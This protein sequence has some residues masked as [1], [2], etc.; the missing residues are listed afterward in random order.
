MM[1]YILKTLRPSKDG[2]M[3]TLVLR[4]A[5]AVGEEKRFLINEQTYQEGGA[6]LVGEVVDGQTV[7]FFQACVDRRESVK[8]ALRLLGYSDKSCHTLTQMLIRR[9][10]SPEVAQEATEEAVRMGYLNERR[11]VEIAIRDMVE[12]KHYGARRILPALCAK[13]Y[14]RPL[15][16][17]ILNQLVEEGE[18]DFKEAFRALLFKKRVEEIEDADERK[19]KIK[20][21]AYT[22]G[23]K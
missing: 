15:V 5:T 11:A 21:L 19:E 17:E 18:V 1:D 10:F 12:R 23:Y 22:Y 9:G 4:P 14:P 3:L 6:P 16:Y 13:G 20:K 7:T 2:G 8:R